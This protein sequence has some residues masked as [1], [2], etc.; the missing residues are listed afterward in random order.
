M[1][2]VDGGAENHLLVSLTAQKPGGGG[3]GKGV[4]YETL[5]PKPFR[6]TP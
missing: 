3:A 2:S 1:V 5:N 4:A 6:R